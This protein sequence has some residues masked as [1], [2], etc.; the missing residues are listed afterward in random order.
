[1]WWKLTRIPAPYENRF[2]VGFFAGILQGACFLFSC[3][4]NDHHIVFVRSAVPFVKDMHLFM[5]P[6]IL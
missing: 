2:L 3:R 1:M 4:H 6:H 5:L